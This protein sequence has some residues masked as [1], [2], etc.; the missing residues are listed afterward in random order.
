MSTALKFIII[1]AILTVVCGFSAVACVAGVN[2]DC[3]RQESGLEAQYKQNQNNYANYFDKIKEMAQ[4]PD[5]YA[6]KLK[7]VYD[8][9]IKGRYGAE[10]SK[11]VFQFIQEQNPNF[12]ASM[13]KNLQD[14]ISAG[15]DA[16]MA[17]QKTLLDKKRVYENTLK[18]FPN[19]FV[20]GFLGFPKK[21][22][23]QFDIVTNDETQ[24]AFATKKAGP[25]KLKD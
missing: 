7:E 5:M 9:A 15:R 10:G 23:A 24:K 13:Y 1:A 17:D 16:F 12:D 4:V 8:G 2:N 19:S 11:A 21:D 6:D 3:V 22:L 18:E 20:A 25:I 14:T